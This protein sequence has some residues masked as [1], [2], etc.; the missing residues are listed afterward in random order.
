MI[1]KQ[2]I[3]LRLLV[4]KHIYAD[5]LFIAMLYSAVRKYHEICVHYI[6]TLIYV[7]AAHVF[8]LILWALTTKPACKV[9]KSSTSLI[10]CQFD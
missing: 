8:G 6:Y 1:A 2:R 4:N 9:Q 5:E 10:G 7:T 3:H